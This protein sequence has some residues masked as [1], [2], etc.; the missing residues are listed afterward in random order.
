MPRR[1]VKLG[2]GESGDRTQKRNLKANRTGRPWLSRK[3]QQTLV[4]CTLIGQLIET[5]VKKPGNTVSLHETFLRTAL[6][7][8]QKFKVNR[9]PNRYY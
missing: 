4:H 1:D 5:S 6:G 2:E 7:E 8:T 9:I 3:C